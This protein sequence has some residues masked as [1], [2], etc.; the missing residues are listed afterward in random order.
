MVDSGVTLFG[1]RGY[2]NVTLLDVA[3]HANAPRG[4]IYHH[5]PGGKDELAAEV[6]AA[7]RYRLE[8]QAAQL[9]V[10]SADAQAFLRAIIDNAR[11]AVVS[12]DY[13]DGCPMGGIMADI[14]AESDQAVR[15]AVGATFH[16]WTDAIQTGLVS[17]GFKPAQ[18]RHVAMSVVAAVEGAV[19]VSRATRD[20]TVFNDVRDMALTLLAAAQRRPAA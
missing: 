13:T 4:S 1:Q 11:R 5:L 15:Q 7:W 9:A 6:A 3:E 18:A 19:T 2:A 16:G 10:R 8:R 12:S 20:A 14:G 17:K